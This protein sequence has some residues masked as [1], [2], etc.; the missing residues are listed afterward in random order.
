[1]I[2]RC[3]FHTILASNELHRDHSSLDN[4][5]D[6][7]LSVSVTFTSWNDSFVKVRDAKLTIL[8]SFFIN[9]FSILF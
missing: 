4:I 5:D 3:Q 9:F 2:C 6:G 7:F 8:M 1:M